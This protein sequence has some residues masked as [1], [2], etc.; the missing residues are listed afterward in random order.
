MSKTLLDEFD[1]VIMFWLLGQNF[2]Q[3]SPCLNWLELEICVK[4]IQEISGNFDFCFVLILVVK[5]YFTRYFLH[6]LIIG[7]FIEKLSL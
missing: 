7:T 2:R 3:T 4:K 1:R 5:S 6:F